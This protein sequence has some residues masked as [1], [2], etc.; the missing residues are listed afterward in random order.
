MSNT[1]KTSN[2]PTDFIKHI[3]PIYT[4]RVR[5][6]PIRGDLGVV[7]HRKVN[8][9]GSLSWHLRWKFYGEDE[10]RGTARQSRSFHFCRLDL[11]MKQPDVTN[12]LVLSF[13]E[14]KCVI[15][16][17]YRMLT[18]F[19]LCFIS[20]ESRVLSWLATRAKNLTT[21]LTEFLSTRT[22]MLSIRTW[23]YTAYSYTRFPNRHVLTELGRAHW[24]S[25]SKNCNVTVA[26]FVRRII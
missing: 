22:W 3:S 23:I 11:F 24:T 20:P 25:L 17:N 2:Q 8:L 5:N 16:I 15:R 6:V 13:C 7:T 4:V 19:P 9:T 12:S 18:L 14:Q 21:S 26:L 10:A 1:T